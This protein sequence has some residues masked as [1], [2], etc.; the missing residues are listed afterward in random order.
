MITGFHAVLI[1]PF[2]RRVSETLIGRAD[3]IGQ[4]AR[5][6]R[7]SGVGVMRL[8]AAAGTLLY[9]RTAQ[10]VADAECFFIGGIRIAGRALYVG[11]R[12]NDFG[13][14]PLNASEVADQ[15]SFSEDALRQWLEALV[16]RHRVSFHE[17]FECE[18]CNDGIGI[19]IA[20][21]VSQLVDGFCALS[22][23]TRERF[24]SVFTFSLASGTEL[25]VLLRQ[26]GEYITA[27]KLEAS[28]NDDLDRS[29]I[30]TP[31]RLSP[32]YTTLPARADY[33]VGE[34]VYVD[35]RRDAVIRAVKHLADLDRDAYLVEYADDLSTDII[36][37]EDAA[38]RI[39]GRNDAGRVDTLAD[40][41]RS[42]SS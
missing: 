3:E 34:S 41:D 21:K 15:V 24:R 8:N 7:S 38:G 19:T 5:I 31:C 22:S 27:K 39:S 37:L 2:E 18:S 40:K 10:D 16:I 17:V 23:E 6:L 1:D 14:S 28:R 25:R 36:L 30:D 9:D 33:H 11:N 12:G 26:L 13:D 35:G 4:I 42:I 20:Y 29:V 32:A